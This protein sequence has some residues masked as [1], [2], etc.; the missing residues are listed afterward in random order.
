MFYKHWKKI[1]LALTGFF[2]ASCDNETTSANGAEE[3]NSSSSVAPPESSAENQESSSSIATEN[4]SLSSS[5]EATPPESSSSFEN[6]MPAYGVPD[7]PLLS[8]SSLDSII[9]QPLYGVSEIFYVC[10]QAEGDS[11]MNCGDGA[12][13]TERTVERW[14]SPSCSESEDPNGE[15]VSVCPEYGVV[16][17][18]EKTYECDGKI[19]NEAEFRSRY[20][21]MVV[22][23]KIEP[24]DTSF[25]QPI[26]LYGTPNIVKVYPNK[27]DQ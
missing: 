1:A 21:K 13:C 2:W 8:S 17:I 14:E 11:T 27:D 23:K 26:A 18:S 10:E 19:Y 16:R 3:P 22:K 15:I 9:A 5:S 12:T 25:T 20:E 7:D 24:I 4:Q 6:I